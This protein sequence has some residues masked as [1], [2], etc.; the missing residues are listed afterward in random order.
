MGTRRVCQVA[1]AMA[2]VVLRSR[3]EASYRKDASALREVLKTFAYLE[4]KMESGA[5]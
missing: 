2:G 5:K 4:P 3:D 1:K